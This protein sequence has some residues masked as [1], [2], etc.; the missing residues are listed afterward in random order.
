MLSSVFAPAII[1][2]DNLT[3]GMVSFCFFASI[4]IGVLF[5]AAIWLF[6]PLIASFF[7]AS[8]IENVIRAM[9]FS[10]LINKV[11]YGS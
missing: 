9:S 3:R 10:I 8:G 4:S 2:T 11:W 6:A 7:D 5:T 1:Q